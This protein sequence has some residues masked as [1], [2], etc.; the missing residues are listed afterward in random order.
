MSADVPFLD[1]GGRGA[2]VGFNIGKMIMSE[3]EASEK[4]G[5]DKALEDIENGKVFQAKDT[6]DLFKQILGENR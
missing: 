2:G 6:D 5:L 4:S 3:L 1:G